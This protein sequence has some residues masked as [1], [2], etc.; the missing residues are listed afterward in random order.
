MRTYVDSSAIN[1]WHVLIDRAI[2]WKS[3]QYIYIFK[4]N[5]LNFCTNKNM[6][7]NLSA[8]PISGELDNKS[9]LVMSFL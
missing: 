1:I 2:W 6:N 3:T 7:K 5:Y 4:S 9:G 8:G